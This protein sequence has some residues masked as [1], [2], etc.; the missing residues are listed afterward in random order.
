MSTTTATAVTLPNNIELLALY[1]Q[2]KDV[3]DLPSD[4]FPP[5]SEWKAEYMIEFIESHRDSKMVSV[6]EAVDET[7]KELDNNENPVQQVVPVVKQTPPKAV[8]KTPKASKPSPTKSKKD[9]AIDVYKSMMVKGA[10]P[11]RKDVIARFMSDVGL[12][13]AG[14]NTY[15]HSI[16]Q[17]F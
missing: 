17:L 1:K 14:A 10:H 11:S 6:E 9:L 15:H 4:P 8:K 12:S 16:K 3:M 7:E 2:E 5:F 13:A